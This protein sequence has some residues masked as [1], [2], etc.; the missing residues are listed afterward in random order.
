MPSTRHKIFK[1][2]AIFLTLI[3][4]IELQLRHG[5]YLNL[6]TFE[7]NFS[8]TKSNAPYSHNDIYRK[9]FLIARSPSDP[10][11][12]R[13]HKLASPQSSVP[14]RSG[15]AAMMD[16]LTKECLYLLLAFRLAN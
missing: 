8:T 6:V 5:V 1:S 4:Y 9:L 16:H 2:D 12:F 13:P 15:N 14:C 3:S 10:P 11:T 7:I